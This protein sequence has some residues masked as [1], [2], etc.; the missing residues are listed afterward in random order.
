MQKSSS[1]LQFQ[2]GP[3]SKKKKKR[4]NTFLRD[5]RKNIFSY[6]IALPALIYVFIYSYCSYPY[7]IIAFQEYS[8]RTNIFNS[9]WI[10]FKN[11]EFFFKSKYAY[12]VTFNTIYLN[13]LFIITGTLVSVLLA[14]M[15]NEL[16]CRWFIKFAQSSMLFPNYISWVVVSYILFSFLST[17]YG[18]INK[19]L[20]ALGYE[21]INW[22]LR[23][24]LWRGIL[25]FA[26]IWKSSGINA[27]IFLAAI[28]G[29]D[30]S[31]YEAAAIDGATR[32]QQTMHITIP[33]I[34]PTVLI[35][36][37]LAVGKV[38]YGDFGMIYAMI[39]DNGVLYRTTDIIDTYVFRALRQIGDPS[40]AMAIG[41]F[42]SVVGF[43]MV[44]GSNKITK[45]F[46]PEGAL[47]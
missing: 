26:R 10:G 41:L 27:V 15:L 13:L 31:Q 5:V 24:D 32:L 25:V 22:Y 28:A 30:D 8:F 14:L 19:I 12:T 40:Q 16:R 46:F 2:N 38:M 6:L 18:L 20:I 11:F 45:R 3:V 4:G 29:I 35:M 42:Q 9:K 44:Y 37:L 7:M 23:A 1:Y 47:F 33:L 43:I 36:T 21:R 39:G 17:E 34:M